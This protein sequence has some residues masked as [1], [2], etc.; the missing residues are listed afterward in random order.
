MAFYAAT[1]ANASGHLSNLPATGF[2]GVFEG[3]AQVGRT[4]DDVPGRGPTASAYMNARDH[5]LQRSD[6][7]Q[8]PAIGTRFWGVN[9]TRGDELSVHLDAHIVGS[10]D[11]VTKMI[12]PLQLHES[13]TD[14]GWN[15]TV[16]ERH[17]MET[18][19]ELAPAPRVR[20]RFIQMSTS[21]SR[22]SISF[23]MDSSALTQTK[24]GREL[25]HMKLTQIRNA[26]CR[27]MLIIIYR[28]LLE[29]H[30]SST[31][32]NLSVESDDV[33]ADRT[34]ERHAEDTF[35]ALQRDSF[36]YE[37]TEAGAMRVMDAYGTRPDVVL[38]PKGTMSYIKTT[39]ARLT[40]SIMGGDKTSIAFSKGSITVNKTTSGGLIVIESVCVTDEATAPTDLLSRNVAI[41]EYVTIG[42]PHG[43]HTVGIEDQDNGCVAYINAE[44][45]LWASGLF[46]DDGQLKT[47]LIHDYI[48][49][50]NGNADR[51][52]ADTPLVARASSE[53]GGV[54]AIVPNAFG[55]MD[56]HHLTSGIIRDLKNGMS[57]TL[58]DSI[59]D[60]ASLVSDVDAFQRLGA[61]ANMTVDVAAA[62]TAQNLLSRTDGFNA[63]N[64]TTLHG[65]PDLEAG[66][67]YAIGLAVAMSGKA[68]NLV[69]NTIASDNLF[70]ALDGS[71]AVGNGMIDPIT[72]SAYA[73]GAQI[74]AYAQSL[75]VAL[76]SGPNKTELSKT[77]C[78]KID[79]NSD[80]NSATIPTKYGSAGEKVL[81]AGLIK[82]AARV[83]AYKNLTTAVSA[84]PAGYH[85]YT[86][87]MYLASQS[88]QSIVGRLYPQA[89][90][91]AKKASMAWSTIE[92]AISTAMPQS[93]V[94]S[95]D[96]SS[97]SVMYSDPASPDVQSSLLFNSL[98]AK[99][100]SPMFVLTPG[101]AYQIGTSAGATPGHGTV[102][103][104]S[105]AGLMPSSVLYLPGGAEEGN[106]AQHIHDALVGVGAINDDGT[107][108]MTPR[109]SSVPAKST[110]I[111]QA[112]DFAGT[113]TNSGSWLKMAL[114]NA[115]NN[116]NAAE[117]ENIK[118]F[119]ASWA[120]KLTSDGFREA[121]PDVKDMLAGISA[122]SVIL[123]TCL[124]GDAAA[125]APACPA[126][127]DN[128]DVT[129]P[130]T[131]D[132]VAG[133]ASTILIQTTA[134]NNINIGLSVNPNR[135][136]NGVVAT[137]Y[138]YRATPLLMNQIVARQ[139]VADLG[140]SLNRSPDLTYDQCKTDGLA[141]CGA[142]PA[143]APLPVAHASSLIGRGG[144]ITNVSQHRASLLMG[145]CAG[146][147]AKAM[148]FGGSHMMSR[149]VQE[150]AHDRHN[151]LGAQVGEAFDQPHLEF[152][153]M[154][155]GKPWGIPLIA[156]MSR[157]MLAQATGGTLMGRLS[158]AWVF[159][160]FN[161][162]C[163]S[164]M[165]AAGV[166]VPF[167]ICL[168]RP[169]RTFAMGTVAFAQKNA[170]VTLHAHTVFK[171]SDS[172]QDTQIEGQFIT[173]C[174][175]AVLDPAKVYVAH[176][177]IYLGTMGGSGRG[178]YRHEHLPL[179]NYEEAAHERMEMATEG[180]IYALLVPAGDS[181]VR[182]DITSNTFANFLYKFGR[183]ESAQPPMDTSL[184][185]R[186]GTTNN[187][188][189]Y[190]G[191]CVVVNRDGSTSERQ[192][193]SPLG[194]TDPAS[195]RAIRSGTMGRQMKGASSD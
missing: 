18:V 57:R 55:A 116:A 2:N 39:K 161:V 78:L 138:V 97:P 92:S 141:V 28:A 15:I 61:S 110:I 165:A 152:S 157:E 86:G 111:A 35:G 117:K 33:W 45:A 112:F 98:V 127:V 195:S 118:D 50:N 147:G 7:H 53:G 12:M 162:E 121:R 94:N 139:Y 95:G 1:P 100:A 37:Y 122:W 16:P 20:D 171:V 113:V 187:T 128:I 190:P 74:H 123:A 67:F 93:W 26:A 129:Q 151:A 84:F 66:I 135:F 108:T 137:E 159:G 177:R 22:S 77:I 134:G 168:A 79:N 56:S 184:W 192:G 114:A 48:A 104:G 5:T 175:A 167:D 183:E 194:H 148:S 30:N 8:A 85:S 46:G 70:E 63:V 91:A 133:G 144:G 51:C 3:G 174:G 88:T 163:I 156:R 19:P 49:S 169:N 34:R 155:H 101:S 73:G 47:H 40:H 142:D 160:R 146:A 176:D 99:G 136:G 149:E 158:M 32:R 182:W 6:P 54:R 115:W 62:A 52:V 119:I 166:P 27:K 64:S 31:L 60:L 44:E 41:G 164:G 179:I 10:L 188:L 143:S 75:G 120:T 105:M 83:G 170:G 81:V 102:V 145:A 38:L 107:K 29:S 11:A 109:T 13:G 178:F 9:K 58:M 191:Y 180:S 17:V 25:Y 90:A 71:A 185:V 172:V 124:E 89:V 126:S 189:L 21:L 4:A 82:N 103:D 106:A 131:I 69:N 76:S 72:V 140:V 36:G 193:T 68:D 186:D 132:A 59:P 43:R 130:V 125:G 87:M 154:G 23:N 153:E 173:H 24:R 65:M 181:N 14:F 80:A 96:I 150:A 42:L